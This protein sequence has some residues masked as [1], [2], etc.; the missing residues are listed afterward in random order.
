MKELRCSSLI[1]IHIFLQ[2]FLIIYIF[3][4]YYIIFS[5]ELILGVGTNLLKS[6]TKTKPSQIPC[7]WMFKKK[8]LICL[9]IKL[10]ETLLNSS[11]YA[12]NDSI[13]ITNFD[14]HAHRVGNF[15]HCPQ[16][17]SRLT[18]CGTDAGQT[19]WK[20]WIMDAGMDWKYFK[21]TGVSQPNLNRG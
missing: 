16:V 8:S 13:C 7:I 10:F 5:N 9:C 1:N 14:M 4:Y 19:I 17:P 21:R 18:R 15:N 11:L 20:F 3:C 6:F 2:F 12:K